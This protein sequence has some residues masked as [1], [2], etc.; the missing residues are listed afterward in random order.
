MINDYLLMFISALIIIISIGVV[1]L[2]VEVKKL[3]QD[4]FLMAERL[5]RNNED[6]AGLCSA[7]VE[8]DQHIAFN[9]NQINSIVDAVNSIQNPPENTSTQA[10]TVEIS[11]DYQNAIQKIRMGMGVEELVKDCGLTIDEAVLLRRLHGGRQ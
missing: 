9:D 10:S 11:Q 3:K 5:R 6:V 8:L 4:N 2:F 1:L 7:A